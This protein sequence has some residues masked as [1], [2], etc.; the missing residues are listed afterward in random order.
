MIRLFSG[1][2]FNNFQVLD[3]QF[4][5]S[6]GRDVGSSNKQLCGLPFRVGQKN[7]FFLS[8]PFIREGLDIG[9]IMKTLYIVGSILEEPQRKRSV[10]TMA[11]PYGVEAVRQQ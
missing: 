1:Y 2:R 8:S 9:L 4:K 5:S 11:E 3:F 10:G 7:G 6:T